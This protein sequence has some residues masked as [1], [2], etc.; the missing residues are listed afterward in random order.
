MALILQDHQ[1]WIKKHGYHIK[2]F[3]R[4]P[5]HWHFIFFCHFLL[6]IGNLSEL[7]RKRKGWPLSKYQIQAMFC[8]FENRP[9]ISFPWSFLRQFCQFR[10][11]SVPIMIMIIVIMISLWWWP[12]S[13]II[14][15]H[16]LTLDTAFGNLSG[17]AVAITIWFFLS[18]SEFFLSLSEFYF[19]YHYL[20]FLSFI[21]ICNLF[22][23]KYQYSPIA[24]CLYYIIY[25]I[26]W[27]YFSI[28]DIIFIYYIFTLG[29][30]GGTE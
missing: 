6:L 28:K 11:P 15:H 14:I 23:Q 2:Y 18:L 25:Y 9:I 22:H 7:W 16:D 24:W 19:F 30:V 12:S 29:I 21:S 20:K 10:R 17:D 3:W 5:F 4:T 1:I 8:S 27:A 26:I 13:I